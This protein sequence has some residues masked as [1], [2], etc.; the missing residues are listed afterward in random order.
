MNPSNLTKTCSLCGQEKPLSAFLQLAG[1][2]GAGVTYGTVCA[3]CRKTQATDASQHKTETEGGS[4]T[5]K[6]GHKIDAKSHVHSEIDK[7]QRRELA[8]EAYHKDRKK[9]EVIVMDKTD[10]VTAKAKEEKLHRESFLEKRSFL[11]DKKTTAKRPV[12]STQAGK[13]AAQERTQQNEQT[14]KGQQGARETQKLT[15]HDFSVPYFGQ[16]V[17]GQLRFQSQAYQ[18]FRQWLGKSAPIVRAT[19]Q[20]EQQ[21]TEKKDTEAPIKDVDEYIER[22][23]GPKKK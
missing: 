8:E 9:N 3:S 20:A 19:E 18:Q 2:Q 7:R 11:T 6:I 5:N 4:T 14:E 16:Q 17:T 10:K 23:W 1:G 13:A 21:R 15:Q 22:T 12:D